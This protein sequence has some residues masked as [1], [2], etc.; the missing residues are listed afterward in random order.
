[1]TGGIL[2]AASVWT[3]VVRHLGDAGVFLSMTLESAGIPVPSEV[4]LPLAGYLVGQ[5]TLVFWP[6]ALAAIAGQLLGSILLFAVGAVGGTPLVA[7]LKGRSPLL[8]RELGHAEAWFQR[9]GERAVAIGRILPG[10]RTYI[11]LPAGVVRMSFSRFVAY[12]LPGT[13]LWSLALIEVGRITGA[14][15][16]GLVHAFKLIEVLIAVALLLAGIVAW[17]KVA[18]ARRGSP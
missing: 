5:G 13:I 11:S 18:R 2:L 7:W 16:A 15:T 12:T 14:G 6:V 1:M 8:G 3:D 9:N 17:R 4:V 10:V